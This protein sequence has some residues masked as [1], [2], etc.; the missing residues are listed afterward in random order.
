MRMIRRA[1]D[2]RALAVQFLRSHSLHRRN[3]GDRRAAC[4][5]QGFWLSSPLVDP[6][7]FLIT[8]G[9]LGPRFPI[10]RTVSA[11]VRRSRSGRFGGHGQSA[12]RLHAVCRLSQDGTPARSGGR[13]SSVSWT[14]SRPTDKAFSGDVV[15]SL[16]PDP[17]RR[18]PFPTQAIEDALLLGT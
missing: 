2:E 5:G 9:E 1:D 17:T 7:M 18:A 14:A 4:G 13:T 12:R 16:W 15:R 6:A 3:A 8:F 10:A 11:R